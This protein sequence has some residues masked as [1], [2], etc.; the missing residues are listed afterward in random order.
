MNPGATIWKP[1]S[2]GLGVL[3]SGAYGGAANE[4][5]D[6]EIDDCAGRRTE[7]E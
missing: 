7:D 1:A 5:S 3:N 6:S 2:S 4:I